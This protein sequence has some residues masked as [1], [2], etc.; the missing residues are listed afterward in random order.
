MDYK[1]KINDR[2]RRVPFNVTVA[3]NSSGACEV[4]EHDIETTT[5]STRG[6]KGTVKELREETTLTA[7][8]SRFK[9]VMFV[10]QWDSGTLS[11]HGPDA[12]ESA[13]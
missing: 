12:L 8:E 11:Y 6:C 3:K 9:S 10:V 2:V 13:S 7:Q 1:F 4:A 5:Y